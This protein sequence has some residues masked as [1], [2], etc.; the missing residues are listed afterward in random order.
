VTLVAD[1]YLGQVEK[2]GAA[3]TAASEESDAAEPV[4]IVVDDTDRRR[5]RFRTTS[6]DGRDVGVTVGRT[7][8][9]GDVLGADGEHVVVELEPIPALAV[10]LEGLDA[11][12]ALAFGHALGNRHRDLAVEEGRALV[13][14][15]TDADEPAAD[16]RA[17]LPEDVGIERTTVPPSVFDDQ[18]GQQASAETT[19]PAGDHGGHDHPDGQH[20][21]HRHEH[22]QDRADGQHHTHRHEHPQDGPD[23]QAHTDQHSAGGPAN[24][25]HTEGQEP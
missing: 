14:R 16:L 12:E 8:R 21:T 7:L 5:S 10:S 3:L 20:H 23:G 1:T 17:T 22:P 25:T 24:G 15:S 13:P 9:D 19:D 4:R 6:V 11:A 18:P 2:L